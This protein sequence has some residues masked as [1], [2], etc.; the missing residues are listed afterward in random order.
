MNRYLLIIGFV[1]VI[2]IGAPGILLS[3]KQE[4]EAPRVITNSIGMELR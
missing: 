1:L 3:Q 2:G 4:N